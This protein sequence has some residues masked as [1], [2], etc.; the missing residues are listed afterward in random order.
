M[1]LIRYQPPRAKSNK[2]QGEGV[3]Q[4]CHDE[5]KSQGL[6]DLSITAIHNII[7]ADHVDFQVSTKI[8]SSLFCALIC[9]MS[10]S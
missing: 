7:R 2:K 1:P 9:F 8:P 4:A 3:R 5:L 6:N 10:S